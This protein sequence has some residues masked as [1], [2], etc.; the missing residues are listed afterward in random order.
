M[1]SCSYASTR[2]PCRECQGEGSRTRTYFGIA[3]QLTN[4][5]A[6]SCTAILA[7]GPRGRIRPVC[8]EK[9]CLGDFLNAQSFPSETAGCRHWH[10]HRLGGNGRHHADPAR[11]ESW[12]GACQFAGRAPEPGSE[13]VAGTAQLGG[14]R[15][16]S[17]GRAPAADVPRRAGVRPQHRRGAGRAGQCAARHRR[18]DAERATRPGIGR[19]EADPRQPS[20]LCR[21][22]RI[23]RWS[24]ARR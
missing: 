21:R 22:M 5:G 20:P 11:A 18:A 1:P 8:P 7:W 2:C 15:R 23:P 13:H 12:C 6:V 24:V 4:Q 10:G 14:H 9:S 19:A 17:S 16:W 3:R